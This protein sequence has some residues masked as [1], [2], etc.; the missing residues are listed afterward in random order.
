[1]SPEW[2]SFSL[3][4]ILYNQERLL[5]I[6]GGSGGLIASH[7]ARSAPQNGWTGGQGMRSRFARFGMTVAMSFALLGTTTPPA[8]AVTVATVAFEAIAGIDGPLSYPC[9]GVATI[10]SSLCP[11]NPQLA[12]DLPLPGDSVPTN[13]H[14]DYGHNKRKFLGLAT[15][16][17][18]VTGGNVA[19][20]GKQILNAGPCA[21][22]VLPKQP[23]PTAD[24]NTV[25]GYC[26]LLGGQVTEQFVDA[27][28]NAFLLDIH[29]DEVGGVWEFT[30]HVTKLSGP[31]QTGLLVG[32]AQW[33]P[34]P[35]TVLPPD[36]GNS[37]VRKTATVF[38]L[39][40]TMAI[41]TT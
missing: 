3:A 9:V 12:T 2:V 35:S 1:M 25:S 30:G 29:F 33:T 10:D 38:T 40:G 24:E 21:F 39:V 16:L 6:E 22:F 8:H 26:G 15:V 34:L 17:C 23:V 14:I 20:V 37:C 28:G 18:E 13:F 31:L 19:K 41:V 32:T 7:V 27:V 4:E 36:P 5:G 11:I